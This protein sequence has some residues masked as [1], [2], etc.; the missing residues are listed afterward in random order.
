MKV[1]ISDVV[2]RNLVGN[3]TEAHWTMCWRG[4][5]SS[6]PWAISRLLKDLEA[7]EKESIASLSL[8]VGVLNYYTFGKLQDP[9]PWLHLTIPTFWTVL[10]VNRLHLSVTNSQ[11]TSFIYL[12]LH[13]LTKIPY[14]LL[15]MI[16]IAHAWTWLWARTAAIQIQRA[17]TLALS[18]LAVDLKVKAAKW[19]DFT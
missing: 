10:L 18:H 12:L 7:L 5:W 13:S 1:W 3:I 6:G 15:F 19:V 14:P 17:T 9:H 16:S 8:E 4:P 2:D 11:T